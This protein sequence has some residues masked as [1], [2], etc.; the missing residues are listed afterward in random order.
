MINSLRVILLALGFSCFS[1]LSAVAKDDPKPLPQYSFDNKTMYVI[2]TNLPGNT[3][4]ILQNVSVVAIGPIVYLQGTE[5]AGLPSPWDKPAA[6]P[7]LIRLDRT[8]KIT[9]YTDL[10]ALKTAISPPKSK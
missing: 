6:S 8:T 1:I 7:V 5:V 9:P 3:G 2:S 10:A 4:A